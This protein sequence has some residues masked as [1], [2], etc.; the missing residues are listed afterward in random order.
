MKYL[1]ALPYSIIL[2]IFSLGIFLSGCVSEPTE[3][4]FTGALWKVTI[5]LQ[6][7]HN[8]RYADEF[9][10]NINTVEIYAYDNMGVLFDTFEF[11]RSDISSNN[12]D[13]DIDLP[14]GNYT[15][16]AWVN[17][18]G[19]YLADN[20]GDKSTGTIELMRNA[21]QE[22][23]TDQ[24]PLLYG[25]TNVTVHRGDTQGEI[26][27]IKNTN[28]INVRCNFDKALAAVV[29]AEVR[30]TGTNGIYDFDNNS[31]QTPNAQT[32]YI[33]TAS[34]FVLVGAGQA[35]DDKFTVMRLIPGDNLTLTVTIKNPSAPDEVIKTL[36]LTSTIMSNPT[37]NNQSML[38]RQDEYDITLDLQYDD[39]FNTWM[40]TA[41]LIEDWDIVKGETGI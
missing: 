6:Y 2:S 33:P 8:M 35:N 24:D 28:I 14:D 13:A 41:I 16:V 19:S 7:E 30:I 12:Y 36:L 22:I 31:V 15:L 1:R 18:S 29:T 39:L 25:T 38:D 3:D 32:Y 5:D 26:K 34:S 23:S 21:S 27:L 40:V 37:Y 10:T 9:P 17:R 4:C 11:L 20:T